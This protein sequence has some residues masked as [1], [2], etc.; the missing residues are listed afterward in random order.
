MKK[1]IMGIIALSQ[2]MAIHSFAQSTFK[3]VTFK[4]S[5]RPS[6]NLSLISE[7]KNAEETI[8][9]KLKETGYKP[10][11]NGSIFNKKNKQEGFYSFSGVQLPELDNQKLD[12]YFRV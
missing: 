3:T 4:N 1:I 10:E 8:L 2:M 7:T 9:A 12:L 6:L 11:K 5:L